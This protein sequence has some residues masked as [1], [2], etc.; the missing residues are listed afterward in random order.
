MLLIL[1]SCYSLDDVPIVEGLHCESDLIGY[2]IETLDGDTIRVATN[3]ELTFGSG[4][5]TDDT[6]DGGLS[7]DGGSVSVLT[8]RMLGVDAPEIAH[9]SSEVADC[10]GP[11]SEAFT[12]SALA[13][14]Q[15][16]L[17]FD[18][19][20]ADR[21]DR[22]LAYVFL[23]DDATSWD[24]GECLD[25]NCT[26]PTD[27]SVTARVPMNEMVIRFGYARVYEEFDDIRLAA[28]LYEAQDA[29]K[30]KNQGL[31]ATCE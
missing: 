21:Y 18:R 5:V 19:E 16:I 4:A 27:D 22:A 6:G 10:Y 1:A 25:G 12:R 28:N 17:S 8:V 23:T 9:N 11:E 24:L 2:V 26:L 7:D 29:A 13:D 15:V 3:S 20:C 14:K 30:A 31:W